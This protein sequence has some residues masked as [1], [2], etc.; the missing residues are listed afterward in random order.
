MAALALAAL[1]VIGFAGR[2]LGEVLPLRVLVLWGIGAVL[3]YALPA[4]RIAIS[5]ATGTLALS[6]LNPVFSGYF[7]AVL[8]VLTAVRTRALPFAVVLIGCTMIWPKTAFSLHYHQAGYWNWFNE[9]SFGLA[10]F[11][12]GVWWRARLDARRGA[13]APQTGVLPFLLL[14]LFPSHAANPVVIGPAL[15]ARPA[16]IDVRGLAT[17]GF[18]FVVKVGTLLTLR[19]LGPGAF[20]RS[21][22][23]SDIANLQAP[24]L[25]GIVV[26]SYVETY[27]V[28]AASADIPVMIGR[29][30]GF[31]LPAAFRAPL[32]AQNPVE[33]WRRW[34][35]YN[36]RVLIELVYLPL[37]GSQRHLYRNVILTFLASA[38][39]LHSGW[40]GSKYW[41]VGRAGWFDQ[42][43]YFLL[44][45][46]AVCAC[47]AIWRWTGTQP[48]RKARPVWSLGA[49]AGVIV[50]QAWSALAHIVVLAP[51]MSMADRARIVGRCLGLG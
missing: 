33:L 10:L 7:V 47:L 2:Q 1:T 46:V 28:L 13:L 37:G 51:E 12:S 42:S 23:G 50:T 9:P 21:L 32:L 15:L 5:V 16:R 22:S 8:A 40:F 14:Y 31:Q 20:L 29:L 43:I 24:T 11:V 18:W 44:Q 35:I 48:S 6:M 49:L 25:W 27:L 3:A 38:L 39:L 19:Q 4:W 34:G 17:L 41:A 36:R 45:A 26:A 30:F